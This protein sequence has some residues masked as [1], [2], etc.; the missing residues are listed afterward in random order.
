MLKA[1]KKQKIKQRQYFI[2]DS[3]KQLEI[4]ERKR[5]RQ[6]AIVITPMS[7]NNIINNKTNHKISFDALTKQIEYLIDAEID[8]IIIEPSNI[9]I[10]SNTINANSLIHEA[11]IKASKKDTPVLYHKV[12]L[13]ANNK[14]F[15]DSL[16]WKAPFKRLT[17][18][19]LWL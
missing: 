18:T 15:R 3:D 14:P 11:M 7:I 1:N 10:T 2:I 9:S 4:L 19:N 6:F 13:T 5:K 8:I 16:I 17:H 12:D